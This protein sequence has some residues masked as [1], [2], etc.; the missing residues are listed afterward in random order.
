MEDYQR[1]EGI[2]IPTKKNDGVK[3]EGGSEKKV[4]VYVSPKNKVSGTLGQNRR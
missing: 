2:Y 3:V 4:R 1:Q